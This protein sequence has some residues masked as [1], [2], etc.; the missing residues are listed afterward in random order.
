[1]NITLKVILANAG[2][3]SDEGY[4]CSDSLSARLKA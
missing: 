4:I 1:M 3:Q 2:T